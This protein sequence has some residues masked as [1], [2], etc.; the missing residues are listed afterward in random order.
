MTRV[1]LSTSAVNG[2]IYAIGGSRT[3]ATIQSPVPIV[4]EYNTGFAPPEETTSVGP[5]GK[6]FKAWGKIK[7]DQ[8]SDNPKENAG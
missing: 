2:K 3:L 5:S 4:E 7:S 6:L 8:S 1:D